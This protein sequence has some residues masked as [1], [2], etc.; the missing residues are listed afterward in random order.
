MTFRPPSRY[1]CCLG[2]ILLTGLLAAGCAIR[3]PPA[4]ADLDQARAAI[5]EAKKAGSLPPEKIEELE[6]RHLQARGVFYACNDAEAS[7][8]AQAIIADARARPMAAPPPPPP[9]Q[10]PRA[11]LQ[12][13]AEG[14]VNALLSFSGEGSSDPEGGQLTYKW[15]FGDGTMASFT[16]P[17]ATHRYARPGNYTVRLTVEDPERLSDSAAKTVAVILR[18]TLSEEKKALFDFDKAT[19]RPDAQQQLASV[20]QEMQENATLRAEMVGHADA[21]GTDAYNMRL[22]QRRAEAVRNFMVSRGIAA[23]R[24]QVEWKGE[25]E[26]VAPNDTKAGRAQNRRVVITLR[27][28]PV[29]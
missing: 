9:N 1:L 29:Q 6:K 16:F 3:E 2:L 22:S 14:E 23:N 5:A 27:P 17:N 25:R 8:L 20:V 4:L 21:I 19:I 13:P 12:G 18:L 28:M 26:P 15:D 7:R 11:R 10:P 24:M